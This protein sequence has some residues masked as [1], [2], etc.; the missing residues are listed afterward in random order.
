M[1]VYGNI[2]NT[3]VYN[4]GHTAVFIKQF[5]TY[6]YLCDKLYDFHHAEVAMHNCIERRKKTDCLPNHHLGFYPSLL[7]SIPVI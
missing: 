5:Y 6:I 7:H 1:Y 4:K 2:R 3:C